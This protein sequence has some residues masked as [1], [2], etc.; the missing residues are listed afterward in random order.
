M[1]IEGLKRRGFDK[2][3]LHAIRNVYKLIYRSGRTLDN[4]NLVPLHRIDRHTAGLVLF[5]EIGRAH[6]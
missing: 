6:V 5:S 2:P 1:N 4:P 3:T